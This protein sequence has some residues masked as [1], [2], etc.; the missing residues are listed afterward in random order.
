MKELNGPDEES[1]KVNEPNEGRKWT[2]S[3]GGE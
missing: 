3:E 2:V 1:E